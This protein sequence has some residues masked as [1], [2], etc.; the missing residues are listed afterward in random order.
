MSEHEAKTED[1]EQLE[2]DAPVVV[3]GPVQFNTPFPNLRSFEMKEFLEKPPNWWLNSG[4]F[5]I[6]CMV[7]LFFFTT[8]VIK[9]PQK[10]MGHIEIISSPETMVWSAPVAGRLQETLVE[11]GALVKKGSPILTMEREMPPS[12]DPNAK[13]IAFQ[14][15]EVNAPVDAQLF[16]I[17]SMESQRAVNVQDSLF[18]LIPSE[19]T[20]SA[21]AVLPRYAV[22]ELAVGQEVNIKLNDFSYYDF[23][24]LKG[25]VEDIYPD[26]DF[27]NYFVEITLPNQLTTSFKK[28][29]KFLPGM[30]G[31]ADI[32]IKEQRLIE[33]LLSGLVKIFK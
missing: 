11:N 6:F 10:Q 9:S 24:L 1:Q 33:D 16:F 22:S 28:E 17:N 29:L 19:A 4:T 25:K 23:G 14:T 26:T 5:T 30:Q 31:Q 3:G 13:P 2:D 18:I 15:Y 7:F 21:K 8:W 12:V 20:Y 27:E 32:I